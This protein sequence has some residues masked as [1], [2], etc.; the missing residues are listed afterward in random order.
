MLLVMLVVSFMASAGFYLVRALRGSL[1]FHLIF[2]LFTLAA[3]V[4]LLLIVS[5][6][7]AA[8]DWVNR[9]RRR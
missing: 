3:P 2:I 6:A 4:F 9:P 8:V 5:I 7:R 1:S